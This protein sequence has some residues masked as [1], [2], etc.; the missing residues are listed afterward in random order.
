MRLANALIVGFLALCPVV[1]MGTPFRIDPLQSYISFDAPYWQQVGPGFILINEDGTET[2]LGYQWQLLMGTE[3]YAIAGVIGIEEVPELLHDGLLGLRVNPLL[4]HSAP[5]EA[6]FKV[7]GE[8][9]LDPVTGALHIAP[10]SGCPPLPGVIYGCLTQRDPRVSVLQGSLIG[11]N[12]ILDG[13]VDGIGTD[14][15]AVIGWTL[16]PPP[17]PAVSYDSFTY[18]IVASIPEPPT[19]ALLML[20]AIPL[21]VARGANARSVLRRTLRLFRPSVRDPISIAA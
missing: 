16:E 15:T 6:R 2:I 1:S 10:Y 7:P 19:A 21:L 12:L 9:L 14:Y 11:E 13:T 8:L 17:T 5:A 3:S 20:C 4:T 18:R